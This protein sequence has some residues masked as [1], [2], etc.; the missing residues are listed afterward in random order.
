MAVY[1]VAQDVEADDKLLGPFTFR[2]FIYL[3]IV[4]MAG[5]LAYGLS[6][7]L[8]PLAIIPLPVI[9][10]FGALA[11]PLRKDQPMETYLAAMISF[12]L[13]PRRRLW[14]PDGLD[15]LI[16]I[17]VPKEIE[18][19]RVKDLSGNEAQERFS[20]LASIADTGGWAVRHVIP[21]ETSMIGDV[22][23]E[24]QQAP[25]LLDTNS[26]VGQSF[27]T[28][29]SQADQK[30]RSDM[31]ARVQQSIASPEPTPAP[32]APVVATPIT[33]PYVSMP[34]P[35]PVAPAADPVG[36]TFNPYPTIHQSVVQPMAADDQVIAASPAPELPQTEKSTSD[37]VVSPDIINLANN[38][39]LSIETIAREAHRIQEKDAGEGEVF[40]SLR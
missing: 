17:T 39:D 12:Y 18:I 5:F 7:L 30:R 26:G 34:A 28:M 4:A 9:L 38:S 40:I 33:D 22:F 20:Y 2:Q 36:V 29:I 23:N 1:K 3:I 21:G 25:D 10:F 31:L 6:K 24:A 13:K 15:S 37:T 32:V 19:H 8:L 35:Q 11:L 27:D 16:E 14:K